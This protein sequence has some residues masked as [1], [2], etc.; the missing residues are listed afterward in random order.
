MC[1]KKETQIHRLEEMIKGFS[2][3]LLHSF[4]LPISANQKAKR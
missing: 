2:Q 1:L 3:M 4:A